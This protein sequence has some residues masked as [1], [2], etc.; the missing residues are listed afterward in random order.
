MYTLRMLSG[1]LQ[2]LLDPPFIDLADA[3]VDEVLNAQAQTAGVVSLDAN[4]DLLTEIQRANAREAFTAVTDASLSTKDKKDAVLALRVPQ[5]VRHLAGM[6]SEYDWEFVEQAK[7][8]RGY[9]VAKLMEETTHPD[10][11]IR[12]RALELTGKLTEIA[13]FSERVEIVH[14]NTSVTDLE[15]RIRAK[16]KS[17]LPPVQEIE[18]IAVT[19]PAPFSAPTKE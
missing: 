5:A 10:A 14:S 8:I 19:T 12:L 2:H 9:V 6:L 17:L 4:S 3:S 18:T 15:D 1:T 7:Q 13:S 16:L 11:R